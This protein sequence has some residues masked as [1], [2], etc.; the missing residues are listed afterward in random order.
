MLLFYPKQ[1]LD[2]HRNSWLIVVAAKYRDDLSRLL[3]KSAHLPPIYYCILYAIVNLIELACIRILT[4]LTI[5]S[6]TVHTGFC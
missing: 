4:T 1:T 2:V 5:A 3:C 6:G